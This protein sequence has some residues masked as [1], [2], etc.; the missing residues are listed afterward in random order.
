M[1]TEFFNDQWRI[2]SNENQNKVS[3]YSMDFD[4]SNYVDITGGSIDLGVESTVS[5]WVNLTGT[6]AYALLGEDSYT[7]DYLLYIDSSAIYLRVGG[8]YLEWS[9]SSDIT[10][11]NWHHILIT[12]NSSNVG[13]LFIDGNSKG[14]NSTW[15][16]G[17]PGTITTKFDRIGAR[18]GTL[19]AVQGKLDAVAVFDYA[20]SQDQVT[21]LGAHGYAFASGGSL[22]GSIDLANPVPLGTNKT[23]SFW[24]K[25]SSSA[26]FS[27]SPFTSIVNGG[28]CYYPYFISSSS[29]YKW[30]VSDFGCGGGSSSNLGSGGTVER[31]K[32]VHA[33]VVGDGSNIKCYINGLLVNDDNNADR[34]PTIQ[35]LFTGM[36]QLVEFSNFSIFNTNL[37]ATGTESIA[38]L[39]NNGNPPDLTNYSNIS[40]W[41]KLNDADTFDGSNWTITDY[42]GGN[43]GTSNGMNASNLVASNIDGELIANPMSLSP[44]PIAYYQLGDQS[45]DNGANYLVPNNSLSDYAFNFIDDYI[46]LGTPFSFTQNLTVSLWVKSTQTATNTFIG[47]D[48]SLGSGG[49]NWMVML[50]QNKVYFWTSSTGNASNFLTIQSNVAG[51]VSDGEWHHIVCVNNYTDS[52]KQIYIDGVLDI[53]NNEGAAISNSGSPVWIGKR[54][55]SSGFSYDGEMS[56]VAL[57]NT[58]LTGPQVT[59]LYNNGAP[60]DIS[61]LSPT[62]WYKLN[63]ADTFDGSNWT[64]KDYAGSND[65]TSSG[66]DSSNL[67]VSDL[68]QT[69]GYSPYA[70][71]FDGMDDF[72]NS[73]SASYLNGLS[74]FSISV[75]INLPT[76]IS[77]RYIVS[78]WNYNTSPFGH[79]ALGTRIVSGS[80]YGLNLFIKQPSDLGQN[81]A[82]IGTLLLENTWHNAIFSYNSGTVTCYLNGSPVAVTVNGT[83]PTT[84][85]SQDGNLNIGKFGGTGTG[86]LPGKLSNIALWGTE[87][88]QANATE[89]Y[90][91]GVPSNLNTFSG[92][93]PLVWW[94]LGS[95]SS[96]NTNW[97]CLNEGSVTGSN[98]VSA[99][100]MTNDDIVNGPGYSANGLGTSSI[101]IVGDAPYSTANGLSE[102]MDVLDRTLD[103]PI[104]NTHSIQL[105]GIDDYINLSTS[106][107]A[108]IGAMNPYSVSAWVYVAQSDLSSSNYFIMGAQDGIDRWYFRIQVGY[109]RFAYG[110]LLDNTTL[111]PITGDQWNHVVFTYNGVDNFNTYINGVNKSTVTNSAT[112][113]VPSFNAFIGALNAG[114]GAINQ[115]K[116][117]MDEVSIFSSELSGTQVTSI[118]NDGVPNNIL[119]LN[120]ALWYRFESLTTNAGVVTTADD[121]GNGLTGL[122][123]PVENG[124]VLS[125]IVP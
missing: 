47:K 112:Q 86:F 93:A 38:S 117:K 32:W 101:D 81:S 16:G 70:L 53:T 91:Q 92:T 96:F 60:N 120:P 65:G 29:T 11:G 84:L 43:T 98:A 41:W 46:D 19:N 63:A 28:N 56:N 78:D 75:W 72:L 123:I 82:Q 102:N 88:T 9:N 8:S 83:L 116:G 21:Q 25:L 36:T 67:V 57:W 33:A 5:M 15:Q 103:T 121:S 55:G 3:N 90:N 87:L 79:F 114:S 4:G 6:Y 37:P 115:F 106:P 69:S 14:T 34:N 124:A 49:R 24:F 94:Q 100:S 45:V 104:R 108:L 42:I 119:P 73:G 54:T 74:E 76:G 95:N 125:T 109:A 20:L 17:D 22:L 80:Y 50:Y 59:T 113:G 62:A 105:D 10:S 89:I 18:H 31:N 58:A 71:D 118:Y 30:Y 111:T 97:T 26:T 48:T 110:T 99:G 1:S 7:S 64:I 85:T 2:P 61:S 122:V 68:Q 107:S 40:H 13:E 66:M 39:Y 77:D 23:V 12:R 51:V 35:R 44:K 27:F 52:T